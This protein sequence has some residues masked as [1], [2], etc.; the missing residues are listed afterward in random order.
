[1]TKASLTT[2]IKKGKVT[3]Q[4]RLQNVQLHSD[5]MPTKDGQLEQ[6]QLI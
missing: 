6:L 4:K 2:E 1:M 3:T 5:C